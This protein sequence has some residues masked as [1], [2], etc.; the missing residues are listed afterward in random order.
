MRHIAH[1]IA[2]AARRPIIAA[3]GAWEFRHDFTPHYDDFDVLASYDSG[4]ELAHLAT[5]RHWDQ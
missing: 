2:M 5:F 4:R 3:R 1:C